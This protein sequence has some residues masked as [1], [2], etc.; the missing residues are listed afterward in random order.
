MKRRDA[1][2]PVSRLFA[3]LSFELIVWFRPQY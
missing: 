2:G 1:L 3:P